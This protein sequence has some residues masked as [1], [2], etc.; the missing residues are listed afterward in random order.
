MHSTI[1]QSISL[2][3]QPIPPELPPVPFQVP[4]EDEP[5]TPPRPHEPA[6]FEPALPDPE[7]S[8]VIAPKA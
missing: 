4:P 3:G 6:P 8:T 5:G 7:P 1:T 2:S